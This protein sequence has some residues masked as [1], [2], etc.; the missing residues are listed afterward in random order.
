MYVLIEHQQ[1]RE[2][3]ESSLV[4]MLE[5]GEQVALSITDPTMRLK[6]RAPHPVLL[7]V[8]VQVKG[9]AADDAL[10]ALPGYGSVVMSFRDPE[11]YPL[12]LMGL[13]ASAS[14]ALVRELRTPSGEQQ[15][16]NYQR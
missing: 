12:I 8:P 5:R 7:I 3:R 15:S 1:Q 2:L 14:T 9:F 10:F 16:G 13:S 6:R 4:E 11:V